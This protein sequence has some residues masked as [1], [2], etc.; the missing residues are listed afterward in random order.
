MS[1]PNFKNISQ[2]CVKCGKCIPS[3][4]I[5]QI[6]RDESTSPR[7]FLDLL[8][9][10]E[11]GDLEL[12][13][14]A[15]N[16]FESCFL[17]TT[18]VQV[19]PGTLPV[20][21]MIEKI[22]VDIANKYGIAWYKKI[23]FYLL[24]NRKVMDFV[25]SFVYF[26][27]P[28]VLQSNDTKTKNRFRFKLPK[29]GK[30]TI[31]PFSSKSFLQ[32]Y[33]GEILSKNKI[34][35]SNLSHNK[36]AIFIGC[37]SNYNYVGVGESLLFILDKLGINVLIPKQECC[38]APAY[39]TGDI[40]TVRHLIK[41]NIIYF[42]DFIHKVDAILI[43]E[44]TCAAM[45]IEDWEHALSEDEQ[46]EEWLK[47]LKPLKSKMQMASLWLEKNT[48]LIAMLR[49]SPMQNQ[50]ITY[51]D[52]CHARKVLKIYQEPRNLL[53][54]NYKMIEMS[55][56]SRC[57]GFGGISMQSDKYDLVVK[58]GE[59]KAKMIQESGA[60]IVSA[61][62]SAC[63]MQLDNA[64]DNARVEATFSHPLELIALALGKSSQMT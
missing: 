38:G 3:C 40:K 14:N 54:Q 35:N 10:Y 42:E 41:K 9:A 63:R 34:P 46:A 56:S 2:D 53:A 18:C 1:L 5:Y 11:R 12:D 21:V 6:N 33:F 62:C 45:L 44:A 31:F 52:P 13:K 23:F 48:S 61:E 27:S 7:G 8:G 17:C 29:M 47:R 26:V 57:C 37:L 4:T 60:D 28:C 30:R 36:V 19:C 50:S 24:K 59:P 22:R 16:I 51:H 58:A 39:F 43:P 25:F 15:K 49:S 20:D 64:M 55:D 32:R